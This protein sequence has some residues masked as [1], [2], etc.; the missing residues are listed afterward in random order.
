MF[1][2]D[3]LLT[4]AQRERQQNRGGNG[5]VGLKELNGILIA[6]RNIYLGYNVTDYPKK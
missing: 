2:D 1:D 4:I 3:P 6:T 5:I